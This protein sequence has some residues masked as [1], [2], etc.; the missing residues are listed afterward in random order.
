LFPGVRQPAPAEFESF[1]KL[2]P[3]RVA[4]MAAIKAWR[5]LPPP[6]RALALAAIE[7]HVNYW[8]QAE[9]DPERI[10]HASTWLNGRRWE[11]ELPGFGADA[12]ARLARLAEAFA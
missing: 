6:E 5:K 4:R 3:R 8:R 7:A 2:Y 11:D 10:P 1:W 9:R 12:E